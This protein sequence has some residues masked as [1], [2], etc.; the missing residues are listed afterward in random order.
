M[1]HT[2]DTLNL[3]GKQQPGMSEAAVAACEKDQV[4]LDKL[5]ADAK[6]AYDELKVDATPTFFINGERL[7][8]AMSFEE[9]DGKIRSLLRK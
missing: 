6:Y 2:I 4:L 9:I 7:K 8:G 5:S 1:E 3:I